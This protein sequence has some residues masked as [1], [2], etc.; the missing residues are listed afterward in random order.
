MSCL[1]SYAAASRTVQLCTKRSNSCLARHTIGVIGAPF[2]KGQLKGGTEKGPQV[3]REAGL[4]GELRRLGLNVHDHG[5]LDF[6]LAA[7]HETELNLKSSRSVAR[8]VAKLSSKVSSVLQDGHLPLTLGGDHSLG[9][10]TV[11]GHA[12]V[13]PN[14]CLLWVDAHADLNTT[15][16]TKTGHLHGMS[17]SFLIRQL[18]K[19]DIANRSTQLDQFEPCLDSSSIA[20]IALRDLDKAEQSILKRVKPAINVF[21]MQDIDRLGIHEVISR[22]LDSVN[23]SLTRPI[24]VSFDIDAIDEVYVPSTGTPVPGGLTVREALVIGEQVAATRL[25]S[26]LDMMEVN[27][28]LGSDQDV[29]RTVNIAVNVILSFLGKQR[30]DLYA[31]HP[32]EQFYAR[33]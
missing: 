18:A 6:E 1:L 10:A 17:A 14:L 9:L 20:Y 11:H 3:L 31:R 12:A 26:G 32:S 23:S 33:D 16:T 5:D 29:R 2:S 4:V 7:E 30:T 28:L 19:L 27:P 22:A 8:A 21:S 13:K 15:E 25:L 24:H